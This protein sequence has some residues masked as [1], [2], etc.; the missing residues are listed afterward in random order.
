MVR[1]TRITVPDLLHHVIQR[2]NRRQAIFLE[3]G[4]YALYCDLLAERYRANSVQCW[5]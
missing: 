3:D 2:G 4:D 5:A 1:L